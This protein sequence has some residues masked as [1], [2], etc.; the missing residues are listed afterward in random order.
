MSMQKC[1]ECGDT[2]IG[3]P[4]TLNT[5]GSVYVGPYFCSEQCREV[6]EEK[7]ER[8]QKQWEKDHPKTNAFFGFLAK[9]FIAALIIAALISIISSEGSKDSKSNDSNKTEQIQK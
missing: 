8:K 9:L 2:I 3:E 5:S 1:D 7:K 4:V 6:Y